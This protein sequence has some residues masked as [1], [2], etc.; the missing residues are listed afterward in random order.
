[1]AASPSPSNSSAASSSSSTPPSSNPS[2]PTSPNPAPFCRNEF[3]LAL[4]DTEDK[5][6]EKRTVDKTYLPGNV[7]FALFPRPRRTVLS[8]SY[9]KRNRCPALATVRQRPLANPHR[10]IPAHPTSH[11]YS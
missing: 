11:P 8:Y 10:T 5:Q 6:E 1:M 9:T 3:C 4:A 7:S 2:T